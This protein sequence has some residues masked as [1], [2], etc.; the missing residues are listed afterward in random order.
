M[1]RDVISLIL[2]AAALLVLAAGCSIG[3]RSRLPDALRFQ[4]G[5]AATGAF[6]GSAILLY[7]AAL[8]E[9]K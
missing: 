7:F 1:S 3:A 4:L 8:T 9:L 5:G 6:A 2:G